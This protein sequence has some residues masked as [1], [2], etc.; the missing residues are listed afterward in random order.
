MHKHDII[1]LP[2]RKWWIF[3]KLSPL[4]AATDG[5]EAIDSLDLFFAKLSLRRSRCSFNRVA[6]SFWYSAA[7]DLAFAILFFLSEILARFLWRVNGVTSLCIFGALLTFFP[8][9]QKKALIVYYLG[10]NITAIYITS[11]NYPAMARWPNSEKNVKFFYSCSS[12]CERRIYT[13]KYINI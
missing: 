6:S 11:P 8:A 10:L 9:N 1:T 3:T 13:F 7:S 12:H 5:L 2:K 4:Y